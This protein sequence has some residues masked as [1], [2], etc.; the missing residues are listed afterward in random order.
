MTFRDI[1]TPALAVISDRMEYNLDKMASFFKDSTK[2]WLRPHY[3]THKCAEIAKMQISRGACG[4]TC[5]KLSEAQ[6]LA[7][8]AEE[9]TSSI[10]LVMQVTNE[11]RSKLEK[12]TEQ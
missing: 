1:Q 11:V 8:S 7:A 6:D 10:N 9:S 12:L 3:K 4:I 2:T 5:S